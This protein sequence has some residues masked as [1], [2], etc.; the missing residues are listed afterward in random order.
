M[1]RQRMSTPRLGL[2]I[3]TRRL[4]SSI[5]I[6]VMAGETMIAGMTVAIGVVMT[7]I[8]GVTMAGAVIVDTIGMMMT[9]DTGQAESGRP[10]L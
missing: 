1:M 10:R 3:S 7:T 8:T 9:T 5:T 4:V 6:V 2:P